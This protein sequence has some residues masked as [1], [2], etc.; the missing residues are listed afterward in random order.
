MIKV[1]KDKI[2][3]KKI[4]NIILYN[5][6]AE[7][8]NTVTKRKFDALLLLFN[9]IGYIQDLDLFLLNIKKI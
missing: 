6:D 1:A 3:Q 2:K 9:V 8:L 5:Q 4:N 7:K